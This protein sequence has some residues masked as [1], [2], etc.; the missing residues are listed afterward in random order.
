MRSSSSRFSSS[1]L[2]QLEPQ[3]HSLIKDSLGFS[4]PTLLQAAVNTIQE[5]GEEK[6]IKGK[7]FK[8]PPRYL[9]I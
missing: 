8:E 7:F 3:I 4:E 9:E 6:E 1:V 5:G 2:G